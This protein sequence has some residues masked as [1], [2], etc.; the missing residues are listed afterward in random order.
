MS[1]LEVRALNS[2]YGD[3]HILFD[4]SLRV[5]KNEVVALLGRNGA[6]K[7]TTLK[8]LMGVV[9]P[10]AGSVELDGVELVG[11]KAHSI[12]REGMQLVHEN[13]RIF[14]SLSVEENII[15]AGLTADDRWPLERIYTMFP[16]LKERRTSRGTDLSG[17]EQQMLAIARALVR[18][19]KILLLDEPFE[20]LAPVIVHDLV[21]ACRE[22]AQAGQTIVL[23][24]QNIAATLALASR[25]YII[26]NGH[27]AHEG[28]AAELK[29]QPGLLQHHLGV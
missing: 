28:P 11:R 22:L 29:T 19:P 3:S 24:E 1:L 8:S 2:Y 7:S 26:N 16:R 21:R 6:G 13:R 12:A 15:L 17:G 25:V 5:E 14:G 4:V 9:T 27:I 20:G 18:N 23:V 10:R